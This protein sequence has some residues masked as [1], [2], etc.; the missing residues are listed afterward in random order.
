MSDSATAATGGQSPAPS[1]ASRKRLEAERAELEERLS[2]LTVRV[3]EL[4]GPGDSVDHAVALERQFEQEHVRAR[5]IQLD[6]LLS[7]PP[8]DG[9][10]DEAGTATI[11]SSVVL[12]FPGDDEQ[13]YVI[14]S[15][16]EQSDTVEVLT[17]DSPLGRAVLGHRAGDVVEYTAPAGTMKVTVV[18][19][20]DPDE[21]TAA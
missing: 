2:S 20:G 12:R 17:W 10:E 9:S 4:S 3:D 1:S 15:I 8:R 11:G 18:S 16:E 13:S 14:A 7:L 5:I 6:E 19:V 21:A